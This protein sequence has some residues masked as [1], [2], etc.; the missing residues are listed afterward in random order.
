MFLLIAGYYLQG[1]NERVRQLTRDFPRLRV[2]A[3]VRSHFVDETGAVIFESA[4]S[5]WAAAGHYYPFSGAEQPFKEIVMPEI[6]IQNEFGERLDEFRQVEAEITQEEPG[7]VDLE[8]I[9]HVVLT[10]GLDLMMVD[11]FRRL[12]DDT[13]QKSIHQFYEEYPNCQK[14]ES[15]K[16]TDN[17]LVGVHVA[18]SNRYPKQFF[19]FMLKKL[20]AHQWAEARKAFEALFRHVERNGTM[21]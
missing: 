10:V 18:L 11:F 17:E 8:Y 9:A 15:S 7:K 16:F 14:V 5:P 1:N 2:T 19:G 3:D 4:L 21:G 20:K 13:L 12:D 6:N